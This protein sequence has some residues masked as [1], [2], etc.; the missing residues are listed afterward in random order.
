[1]TKAASSVPEACQP[2]S[3]S[4]TA[5]RSVPYMAGVLALHLLALALWIPSALHTPLLWGVGLTAYLFGLRHAWDADHIAVIDNTVRKLL[6]LRQ[7]AHGVGLFFSLGHASVVFLMAAVAA[8]IGKALLGY[9]GQIGVFGGWVGPLVAGVYLLTVATVNL[10]SAFQVLRSG[11][12][13]AHHHNHGGLLAR[14]IT[15]LTRLVSRQWQVFPL[16][17]LMGLGFDTASEVALLALAG[18]AAQQGLSVAA[19]LSL[20]L[21]FAAGMTL[22]DTLDGWTVHVPGHPDEAEALLQRAGC[23]EAGGFGQHLA[24]LGLGLGGATGI[25]SAARI[26]QQF[27]VA[28]GA[29]D[30]AAQALGARIRRVEN[31]ESYQEGLRCIRLTASAGGFGLVCQQGNR[32][33]A[34]TQLRGTQGVVGRVF[35]SGGV[36]DDQRLFGLAFEGKL[37]GFTK[38]R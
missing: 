23:R 34:L 26:C 27:L 2:L 15:P 33:R 1:M 19:I 38:R 10:V 4:Q 18:S 37:F 12:E 17:F 6:L 13:Q 35:G 21:L 14:L 9:Q 8:V 7:N 16:G 25:E 28:L 32:S 5:Q 30:L 31:V 29:F 36:E 11:D 20:P 24:H 22:L 3:I